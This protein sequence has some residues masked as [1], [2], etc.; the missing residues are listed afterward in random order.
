MFVVDKDNYEAEVNQ[1]QTPVMVD[2][3]G[4]QCG[5]CLELL[6]HVE[7]LEASYEG[8]VKFCK[9]NASENRRHCM[10]MKVLGLPTFLFYKGGEEV[11]RISG[12][13]VTMDSI[14]AEL[15]KIA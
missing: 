15:D 2:I 10:S 6:P 3:W 12:G 9:L 11:A 7:A 4:P 14:K 5:P 13:D 8:K 1:S